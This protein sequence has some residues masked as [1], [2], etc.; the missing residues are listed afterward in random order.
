MDF[1]ADWLNF[2]QWPAMVATVLAAWLVGSDSESRRAAGFW[3]F[4]TSNVLWVL[5]G[6]HDGAMALIA[7]SGA[8]GPEYPR[9][10]QGRDR[11][12]GQAPDRNV[13]R[14]LPQHRCLTDN[15]CG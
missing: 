15:V 3:V 1:S 10:L 9:R 11:A 7:L 4:L 2:M 6:L 14:L 13:G 5:W 8:R 12:A